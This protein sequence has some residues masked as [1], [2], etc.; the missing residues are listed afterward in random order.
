MSTEHSLTKQQK[1]SVFLLQI[2]T[3]L[4]YFDLMLYVHMAVVLNELFFPPTDPQM[5]S[6]LAA[7]AFCSTYVL[8]PFGAFI[9]GYIGDNYGR[10]PTVIITTTIMALCCLMMANLPTYAEIGIKA[11]V[12]V[13][14]LRIM[15]GMSS[16]GEIMGARIYI[17][18]ITKPPIQYLSVSFIS[19]ASTIGSMFALG[20]ATLTTQ[21]GFNWRLAF[22]FGVVIAII[23]I[24]ARTK[25]RETPEFANAKYKM[26]R[27][28]ESATNNGLKKPAAL[29]KSTNFLAKE[30]VSIRSFCYFLG[31]YLGWPLCF[32]LI[33]VFFTPILKNSCGYSSEDVIFHNFL[34]S[35]IAIFRTVILAL[36]SYKIYPIYISKLLIYV[37]TTIILILPFFLGLE[38]S[39]YQIFAIQALIAIFGI[40][41][42]PTDAIFIKH[43]PVFQR[44]T[45]VTF[46]YALSRAIMYIIISFGLVFLTRWL[47]YYG[48]WIIALPI[49]FLWLKSISYYESL[50]EEAE[51]SPQKGE[52][53]VR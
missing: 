39:N 48:I 32:Y 8:R 25:L 15:Q 4:E 17:T 10:K 47:G 7:F 33:Y 53:Q 6:V 36:F 20:I 2:G 27:A 18:E 22:W 46:G 38:P 35:I 19:I 31:I 28:I 12:I 16:M 49:T 43:F 26:K 51:N 50:E 52:W 23:G 42:T 44:F 1:E 37:F 41:S 3:F 24:V 29:L 40:S 5:A 14:V 34:L 9:F 45:A 11:A 13:S 30:K 21:S